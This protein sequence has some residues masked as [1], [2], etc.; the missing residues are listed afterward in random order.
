MMLDSKNFAAYK[1]ESA[2]KVRGLSHQDARVLDFLLPLSRDYPGI[3]EWYLGKVV[4]GVDQEKRKIFTYERDGRIA[5]IGIAKSERGEKKICTVRV[6]PE[7]FGR[8]IGVRVFEEL[9]TW[10]DVSKPILTVAESK[11]HLFERIFDYYGFEL[12]G[13]RMGMY[14]AGATELGFNGAFQQNNRMI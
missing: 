5:A 2:V 3:E 13:S 12:S 14:V 6:H 10:L 4:P 11:L 1:R 8:G 7:Y 9:L